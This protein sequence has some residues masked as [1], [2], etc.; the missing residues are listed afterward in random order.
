MHYQNR[1]GRSRLA[2]SCTVSLITTY[3]SC[4]VDLVKQGIDQ[5]TLANTRVTNEAN[6]TRRWQLKTGEFKSLSMKFLDT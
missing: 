4:Q 1:S 2:K 6:D 3:L 5:T